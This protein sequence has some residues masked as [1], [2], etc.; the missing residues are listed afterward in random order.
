MEIVEAVKKLNSISRERLNYRRRPILC[1]T[2]Y[3]NPTQASN[4][5]GTFD[6]LSFEY[7]MPF[8]HKMPFKFISTMVQ[9]SQRW[10][11]TQVNGSCLKVLQGKV[12]RFSAFQRLLCMFQRLRTYFQDTGVPI[13]G[14]MYFRGNAAD[15]EIQYKMKGTYFRRGTY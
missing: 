6:Q 8:S 10:P 4:F 14:G 5:S 1:A 15:S 3:R 7:F 2:L 13:F 11:K 9:K 12:R